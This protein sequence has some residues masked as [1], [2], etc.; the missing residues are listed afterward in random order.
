MYAN[1]AEDLKHDVASSTV[2][3]LQ[4]SLD[5]EAERQKLEL[6]AQKLQD[7]MVQRLGT[8]AECMDRRERRVQSLRRVEADIDQLLVHSRGD[9]DQ[10]SVAS[11]RASQGRRSQGGWSG[12]RYSSSSSVVVGQQRSSSSIGRH[13]AVQSPSPSGGRF[14][15]HRSMD[16]LSSSAMIGRDDEPPAMSWRVVGEATPGPS[17]Y[18]VLSNSGPAAE[19]PLLHQSHFRPLQDGHP[20][21]LVGALPSRRH[22]HQQQFQDDVSSVIS[23]TSSVHSLNF[24]S[25]SSSYRGRPRGPPGGL[26]VQDDGD[27]LAAEASESVGSL[28]SLLGCT[29]LEK[30]SRT[31]LAMSSSPANC[32][33]MRN[34]R[35]VPLLVRLLHHYEVPGQNQARSDDL[36]AAFALEDEVRQ[37]VEVRQRAARVLRNI[38]QAHPNERQR[39]REAKILR[40]IE[41]L[42]MY[43]DF[44]RDLHLALLASS[45]DQGASEGSLEQNNLV[46]YLGSCN[47]IFVRSDGPSRPLCISGETMSYVILSRLHI[48]NIC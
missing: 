7:E 17:G 25:G 5:N 2:C 35:V 11:G 37:S 15:G 20:P 44:L 36:C 16:D 40:L 1:S 42:R 26:Q 8:P 31:F 28:V 10:H 39:K 48:A 33:L 46:N 43:A 24:D 30:M 12:A 38:V 3:F 18:H 22:H 21:H 45:R 14:G 13:L 32:D 34:H 9:D 47:D 6:R 29:D 19:G 4:Y 23:F 27:E 41:V